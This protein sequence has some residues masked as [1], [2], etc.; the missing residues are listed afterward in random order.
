MHYNRPNL[1]STHSTPLLLKVGLGVVMYTILMLN[2]TFAAPSVTVTPSTQTVKAGQKATVKIV[3]T[4]A[5]KCTVTG[6]TYNKN[7]TLTNGNILLTPTKT[8]TYIFECSDSAGEIRATSASVTVTGT[9]NTTQT[10]NNPTTPNTSPTQNRATSVQYGNETIATEANDICADYSGYQSVYTPVSGG[11][12]GSSVPV[13]LTQLRPYLISIDKNTQLTANEIRNANLIRFCRELPNMAKASNK[14]AENTAKQLKTLADSCVADEKCY[15]KR[16]FEADIQREVAAMQ[17]IPNE[18]REIAKLVAALVGPKSIPG[19]NYNYQLIESCNKQYDKRR[20][21]MECLNI[22]A[23]VEDAIKTNY[24]NA[25]NRIVSRQSVLQAEFFQNGGL[26]SSRPCLKTRSGND[27][28]Q[29]EWYQT[30]CEDYRKQPVTVNQEILKQITA[31]P[32]TQAYSPASVLGVDQSIDNLNTRTR[33]GNLIDPDISSNFG[34]IQSGGG[35]PNGGGG[36]VPGVD[37][38]SV[39]PNYK[40]ILSNIQ[41]ISTLY[42]VTKAAYAS[43]TSICK[44]IPVETRRLTIQRVDVAK[45]S[46]T[47]YTTKLTTDWNKAQKTPKENH[48]NLVTQI[49]FDLKD[50]YNQ[51]LINQVYDAVKSLL[52]I[53]VDASTIS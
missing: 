11:G 14:L 45:K 37:L 31:L 47:D 19:D 51:T 50:K 24:Y 52:Q 8:S 4:G 43:T 48:I 3:T 33:N 6:D 38:K 25:E 26:I 32:Y 35:N 18:G 20:M 34:S 12:G 9:Q 46:Y 36:G 10:N 21:P 7:N 5:I 42:D 2:I 15:L 29:V 49:N 27:P 40:K 41:V 28:T 39:E 22:P 53:C 16:V 30:D 17:K 13:D 23:Q 1:T 44:I